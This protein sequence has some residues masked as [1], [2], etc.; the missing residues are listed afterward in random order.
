MLACLH[1]N[2]MQV[3]AAAAGWV[4]RYPSPPP[5]S[6]TD[7]YT[8]KRKGLL[9]PVRPRYYYLQLHYQVRYYTRALQPHLRLLISCAAFNR[10]KNET[11]TKR[12]PRIKTLCT[13]V[14]FIQVRPLGDVGSEEAN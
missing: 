8:K 14:S 1:D 10:H 12:P 6:I 13:S 9:V 2:A 7:R 11:T 4:Y 3:A 5:P